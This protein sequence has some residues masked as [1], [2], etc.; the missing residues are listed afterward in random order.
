[1]NTEL[2]I[3]SLWDDYHND[4]K[5][6][7]SEKLKALHITDFDK[8]PVNNHRAM[9]GALMYLC[10]IPTGSE[11][12]ACD[13]SNSEPDAA[14]LAGALLLNQASFELAEVALRR[15]V[16]GGA[17]DRG[18]HL[19]NLGRALSLRARYEEA[20]PFLIE[21]VSVSTHDN[22][23]ALQS[24]CEAYIGL[25][26]VDD[27]ISILSSQKQGSS[28]HL[29]TSIL[30]LEANVLGIA[31]R[32]E[33]AS[34][35]VQKAIE[36]NPD[37]ISLLLLASELSR[38]R[39]REGESLI[40]LQRARKLEPENITLLNKIVQSGHQAQITSSAREAAFELARIIAQK[41]S[42][43]T[44]TP[45]EEAIALVTQAYIQTADGEHE[46]AETNYIKA[47]TLVDNFPG[48]LSGLGQ[49]Y[50]EQGRVI[51]AK[52]QFE[53]LKTVAPLMGW[54]QLINIRE[55]PEDPVVL[56]QMELMARQPSLEGP[57][58]YSLLLN[59]A[60]AYD[61]KKDYDRAMQLAVEAN[62]AAKK[63]LRYD[64]V[65]HR[66]RI[67][68][69][70]SHFSHDFFKAR[71]DYGER[72][73]LPVFVLGMPRSGTTLTEQILGSHSKVYGA[74]E[75][76]IV[77]EQIA[78]IEAWQKKLGSGINYPSC[79]FDINDKVIKGY[80]NLFIQ[81]LRERDKTA[82]HIVDKLPHNFENI[83]LIKL[84]FPNAKIIHCRREVRDI[85][86]SNF[87]TDY[88]AKFGGMGFAYD[89]DWIGQQLVDHDRI[90]QHWHSVFPGE[91]LEV[92][93][94]D[95]V[96]DTERVA[97]SMID[98][99]GLEWENTV[100]DHQ[101]LER[102]VKTASVWQV[103]QPIYKT[104]KARWKRYGSWLKPLENALS[105]TVIAPEPE[106][107]PDIEP[108]LFTKGTALLNKGEPQKA[109]NCFL[110]VLDIYPKHAAAHHFLG[111]SQLQLGDIKS[112][113][114]NM[115]RSVQL[116]PFHANWFNNLAVVEAQ[117]GNEEQAE[118]SREQATFLTQ[119]KLSP[120]AP[121]NIKS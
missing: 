92:V 14:G 75:L 105:E 50:L 33:E 49:L 24:L 34:E 4:K 3:S 39:G 57:M 13:W 64:P 89:F 16:D 37:D 107:L 36:Q 95:L 97:K 25:E 72:S 113:L 56:E 43:N 103:R 61:K 8:I 108:S 51:E 46:N 77:P 20:L 53:L 67:D 26:R 38:V 85:A 94:E 17:K 29:D 52:K 99:M 116:H 27:A 88:A 40:Y 35:L 119:K 23:I 6:L 44:C 73:S 41:K 111:A 15:A 71:K 11:L 63:I 112:A 114:K 80:A 104:S 68:S 18:A 30:S 106:P 81:Q 19:I 22:V 74:G 5:E 70:I 78:K 55:V 79:I 12:L 76:G 28:D 110:K 86:V 90:M 54:N 102:S 109:S 117:A 82:K 120:I 10:K 9:L 84:L 101:S 31:N 7:V 21:G 60:S 118:K 48:A 96:D 45:F 65:A 87:M 121:S 47:L 91:I 98:Y 69:I 1:M 66:K 59:I 32:H 2:D 58:R 83:G 93:Y 115:R 42:D 100:L 62:K